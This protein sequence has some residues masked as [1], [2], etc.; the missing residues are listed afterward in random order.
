MLK[1]SG[2]NNNEKNNDLIDIL[3]Q[4]DKIDA[5]IENKEDEEEEEKG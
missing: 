2:Q 1:K 3:G 4:P 5:N